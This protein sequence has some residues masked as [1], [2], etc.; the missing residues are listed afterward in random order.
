VNLY[1]DL[2]G[3]SLL[4]TAAYY[5]LTAAAYQTANTVYSSA[6]TAMSTTGYTAVSAL[7]AATTAMTNKPP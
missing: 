4:D 3:F 5:P 7:A 2:M 1:A 6:A